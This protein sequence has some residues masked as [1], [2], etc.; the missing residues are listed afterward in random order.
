MNRNAMTR[1]RRLRHSRISGSPPLPDAFSGDRIGIAPERYRLMLA[2]LVSERTWGVRP[3]SLQ[4]LV[5]ADYFE[6]ATA[7]LGEMMRARGL[8]PDLETYAGL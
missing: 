4:D 7:V 5:N 8:V 6:D 1:L 2:A 3:F